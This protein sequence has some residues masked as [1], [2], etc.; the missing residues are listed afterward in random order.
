MLLGLI[1]GYN[2]IVMKV[3]LDYFPPVLFSAYRFLLGAGI[4]L[5][6]CSY[7]KIPL[8]KK[9]DLKWYALCG[10]LQ[11][12]YVFIINQLALQYLDA[13]LTSLL[14]Y[15]MPI[16]FAFLAHFFIGER[17]TPMKILALV[18]G[19]VGLFMVMEVNPFQLDWYGVN[20]IAQLAVL[21]GALAWAISNIIVKKVL[22]SHNKWQFSA[23]QML[24]GAIVLFLYSFLFEQGQTTIWNW[25]AFMVVFYAGAIASAL[26]FVLW[27]Y[28]LSSGEGGKTTLSLLLVPVVSILSG[29]LFLDE[30]MSSISI[31][32][33]ITILSAIGLANIK[34][35]KGLKN[36][37]K[38]HLDNP[39]TP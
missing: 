17:L 21:S 8:P 35:L 22:H 12:S 1:W 26:A 39:T 29:W 32:G 23:Y 7:K 20:L 38:E 15:T 9:S 19:I 5:L 6:I 13:G 36:P 16:W 30:V 10:V 2:F 14:V 34:D 37:K 4:L 31:I 33:I 3:A 18:L 28:L 11:T 24:I 25:N 27:F